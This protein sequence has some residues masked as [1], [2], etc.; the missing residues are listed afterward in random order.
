[1]K[2]VRLPFGII[3]FGLAV[4]LFICSL[5]A[6]K[7]PKALG[8]PVSGMI[9][10]LIPP[11][12]GNM[13]IILSSNHLLSTF[14]CYAYYIGMD[15]VMLAL[16]RFTAA[17]CHLPWKSYAR[18]LAQLVL[19]LDIISLAL[20]PFF[21]HA[22]TTEAIMVEG[23]AYYRLVPFI[24]Q[25]IHRVV[26]YGILAISILIF[27]IK[28]FR[29]PR[30]ESERYSVIL[31]TMLFTTA[32]ESA[33]IFSGAPMDRAMIGF[34]V[35]GLLIYY[36]SLHYRPLRL[37][38]S[39]L[40]QMVSQLPEAMFFF[41]SAGQCFWANGP[42]I[43]LAELDGINF[44]PAYLK[45]RSMFG[46]EFNINDS[47]RH[48][49]YSNESKKGYVLQRQL[50]KDDRGRLIGS[51]LSVRDNTEEQDALRQ[52]IY[53]ATHDALTQL[54]NRAGYNFLLTTL[55]LSKICLLVIDVDSFK[56][57]NDTYGHE[58][59]DKVLQKVAQAI[60][61]NFR[62]DDY[63]CRI[64]G[65][66]FVVL[67]A[68]AT[69]SQKK[70]ITNRVNRINKDLANTSDNLPAIS[71]SVGAV[72]G[73]DGVEAKELFEKADSALYERK[74][75]GKNGITFSPTTAY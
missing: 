27:V 15:F 34:G 45:L 26:D 32:W 65:D 61:S 8:K 31:F 43:K 42:G 68:N 51:F 59:G 10:S 12:I 40:A 55:D 17:Y 14:G 58:V 38:D 2:S 49:V 16:I 30:I 33:Y 52:E 39:I 70:I 1:M 21:G 29:S 28:L 54:H 5:K 36:L 13:I 64:G 69:E 71:V 19:I 4:A 62:T 23:R 48:T 24:G 44:E 66:E 57:V 53:K 9:G 74:R 18:Q 20:N 56:T 47:D 6:L 75:N 50:A 35:F 72:M 41:D 60:K 46:S 7:S 63:V 25:T 3:L 22:F 67:I 11:V 37:L 73:S